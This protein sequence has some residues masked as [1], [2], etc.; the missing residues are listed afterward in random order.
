MGTSCGKGITADNLRVGGDKVLGNPCKLGLRALAVRRVAPRQFSVPR[1]KARKGRLQCPRETPGADAVAAADALHAD[2]DPRDLGRLLP[3]ISC[4]PT[5]RLPPHHVQGGLQDEHGDD[6]RAKEPIMP[7]AKVSAVAKED[8]VFLSI[9]K[10][11]DGMGNMVFDFGIDGVTIGEE[12]EL[13]E[14]F[15]MAGSPLLEDGSFSESGIDASFERMADG[16]VSVSVTPPKDSNGELPAKYFFRIEV[17][18]LAGRMAVLLK[19]V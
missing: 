13:G 2:R 8:F 1:K 7:I 18:F 6:K 19:G 4:P 5:P 11:G 14:V 3:G 17:K 16:K 12:A 10:C 15:S 9:T